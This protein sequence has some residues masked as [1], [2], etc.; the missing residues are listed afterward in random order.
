LQQKYV[1]MKV[2][3]PPVLLRVEGAI[4]LIL[5]VLLYGLNNG[6]GWLLF[7]LLFLVPDLSM[8]GYLVGRQMGAVSYNLFHTYALPGLLASFGGPRMVGAYWVRPAGGLW[9]EVPYRV[10]RYP[11]APPLTYL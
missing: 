4:L 9:A 3:L 5:S 1:F 8:L 2:T 7:A 10:L 6:G 11:P